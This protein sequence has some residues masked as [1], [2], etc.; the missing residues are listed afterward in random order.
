[1]AL[2]G[3]GHVFGEI[4]LLADRPRTA[5]AV[6][7]DK[8]RLYRI[9]REDFY[10][11]VSDYPDVKKVLR[12]LM[13]ER[14][15]DLVRKSLVGRQ[16][17]KTWKKKAS[18]YL[19]HRDISPTSLDVGQ[20]MQQHGPATLGIWLGILL[21]GIP[22]SIVIGIS[23]TIDKGLPL[24][25]VA[26][27][28]LSNL[29]EAMSSSVLMRDRDYSRSRILLMWF[30]ITLVTA[31]GAV[32]GNMFFQSQSLELI[33]VLEGMAA[34]AM[35]TMIA[36]TMLPEAYEHGGAIVGLSTLAGFLAALYVKYL[37]H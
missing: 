28:F 24:P 26:G 29:P 3:P 6:T 35:L 33:A 10:A 19:K 21:D 5:T 7:P 9:T 27:V 4:G 1:M 34:G 25:L 22:E 36:E 15:R 18:W 8:C 17:A 2:L 13:D 31:L 16:E 14:S 12:N 20:R 23:V 30:S 11:L 37:S 32:V